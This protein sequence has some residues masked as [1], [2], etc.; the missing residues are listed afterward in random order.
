MPANLLHRRQ[1]H[2]L[3]DANFKVSDCWL[4]LCL[5]VSLSVGGGRV[6]WRTTSENNLSYSDIVIKQTSPVG[7]RLFL[8]FDLRRPDTG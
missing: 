1:L 4:A 5:T 2:S 8:V 6:H 7:G 3:T